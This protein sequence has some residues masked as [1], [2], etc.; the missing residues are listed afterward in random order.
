MQQKVIELAEQLNQPSLVII[1]APTGTGKT[2]AAL[3]LAD[4]WAHHL[5]QRGMYV[6]MPTMATSNQMHD[7]VTQ[8]LRDRYPS[9]HIDPLLVHSQARWRT[10]TPPPELTITDERFNPPIQPAKSPQWSI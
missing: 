8:M 7:R 2:E 6:A 10:E 1:E 5:Q 3:Y 4:F 9:L